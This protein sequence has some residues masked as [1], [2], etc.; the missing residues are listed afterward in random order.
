M[1]GSVAYYIC[2]IRITRL[3]CLYRQFTFPRLISSILIAVVFL[4]CAWDQNDIVI[5]ILRKIERH[6]PGYC[7]SICDKCR[8]ARLQ[9]FSID[10]IREA[11]AN[12]NYGNMYE[13]YHT[14]REWG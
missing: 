6:L 11:A 12:D 5:C 3:L 14:D 8:C 2:V 13:M 10:Q 4:P 7:Q 9:I 1:F